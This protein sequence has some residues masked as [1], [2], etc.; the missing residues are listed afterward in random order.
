MNMLRMIRHLALPDWWALRS[1]PAS[2]QRVIEQ[3]IAASEQS[4]SGELRFAAEAGLPISSLLADQSSRGRAVDMFAQLGVW[5]TEY[6]SGVLIYVQLID[7]RVEIV[8]DRGIN[9]RVEQAF[10][11]S[12]CRDL[13]LA[14]RANRFEDGV[15]RA[16]E[17]ISAGLR[18]H[19]PAS[20]DEQRNPNE[21]PDKP[22][23]I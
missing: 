7:R 18:V 2:T 23:L 13:E 9:A 17:R 19:F 3:A 4:H 16:I 14:F 20:S 8:A 10:W 12:I 5:D 11:D 1:F 21:L 22:V 6:N 15:V